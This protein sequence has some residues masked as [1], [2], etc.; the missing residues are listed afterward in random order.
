MTHQ[1]N[2]IYSATS[3]K[4]QF[5][6]DV[7]FGVP[8]KKCRNFGICRINPIKNSNS[9]S[10][11]EIDAK[12]GGCKKNKAVESVISILNN[13]VVEISFLRFYINELDHYDHF[14]TGRFIVEEDFDFLMEGKSIISFKIKKGLYPVK[15]SEAFITVVFEN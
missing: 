12:C 1:V 11:Q 14:N 3:V 6:A 9:L 13:D 7:E 15:L 2:H 4:I 10:S 5:I 8:S